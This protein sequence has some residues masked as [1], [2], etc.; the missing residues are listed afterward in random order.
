M[1]SIGEVVLATTWVFEGD[2]DK[3]V[4]RLW[5]QKWPLVMVSIYLMH[6][7]GMLYSDDLVFGLND[8]RIKLPLL[9]FP[10][11]LGS[12]DLPKGLNIKRVN[13]LFIIASIGFT[14]VLCGY[15]VVNID[16]IEDM[17][18]VSFLFSH[19][20]LALML[21]LAMFLS[22]YY[23][24]EYKKLNRLLFFSAAGIFFIFMLFFQLITGIILVVTLFPLFV[25]WLRRIKTNSGIRLQGFILISLIIYCT[26]IVYISMA[27]YD[28]FD[29]KKS[30]EKI[31]NLEFTE[32]GNRYA[33]MH[34]RVENGMME[35]GN[36]VFQNVIFTELQKEWNKRSSVEI[37]YTDR[38][39]LDIEHILMR[40][41][42]SKGENKDSAA[43][44]RL[45]EAEIKAI[46]M[47]I[48]NVAFMNKAGVYIRIHQLFWEI[49]NYLRG[50]DFNGH[51]L[52][53]RLEY[54]KTGLHV[55]RNNFWFGVGTGD[56]LNQLDLQ[57]KED[58][59]RLNPKW[60]LRTHNQWLTIALTFGFF[61]FLLFTISIV[62]PAWLGR[63]TFHYFFFTAIFM[64]SMLTEDTLETQVGA[65]FYAFFNALYFFN[66]KERKVFEAN[67]QLAQ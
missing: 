5:T 26:T 18:D 33:Q 20:R 27:S 22:L 42:T 14:I 15:Y 60:R 1:L 31:E 54:W 46:E 56:V 36:Y 32:N 3:K 41:L 2:I 64:L 47:G 24:L 52:A 4:G 13:I 23:G 25:M 16:S 11:V 38:A 65:T 58:R 10:I 62:I 6:M 29:L 39:P 66:I 43:V 28:Y 34:K 57:Y 67:A 55:F 48:T 30:S 59:S 45:T 37:D 7:L 35:N 9:M 53:M 8:L 12:I 40:F 44:S 51:S 61:G 19:I 63:K 21:C 50:G 17:R 49:D